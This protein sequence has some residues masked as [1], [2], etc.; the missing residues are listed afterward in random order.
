MSWE[1]YTKLFGDST[2]DTTDG[3]I[4]DGLAMGYCAVANILGAEYKSVAWYYTLT[5][6][7]GYK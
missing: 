5:R 6:I 1:E 4:E 3:D 2:D 7:E